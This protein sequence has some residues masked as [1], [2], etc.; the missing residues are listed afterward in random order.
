MINL[1]Y[2]FYYNYLPLLNA[3]L[4]IAFAICVIILLIKL[5]GRKKGKKELLIA[6]GSIFLFANIFSFGLMILISKERVYLNESKYLKA[7]GDKYLVE[8]V[9]DD[10]TEVIYSQKYPITG[11]GWMVD[12]V[13]Y[14]IN[15]EEVSEQIEEIYKEEYP[16]G[17]ESSDNNFID[18][19][20]YQWIESER[21][22]YDVKINKKLLGGDNL[23]DYRV[24]HIS[25]ANG[26]DTQV[27]VNEKTGRFIHILVIHN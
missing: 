16:M 6:L 17:Y 7:K 18:R 3:I 8:C 26:T 19:P 9:P 22:E 24:V 13:S 5:I 23:E 12:G 4:F 27:F 20:Y 2:V 25:F 1:V 15:P 14:K 21:N 10:A 11:F